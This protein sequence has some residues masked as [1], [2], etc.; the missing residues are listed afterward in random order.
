MK[1]PSIPLQIVY[2]VVAVKEDGSMWSANHSQAKNWTEDER[3]IRY[4]LRH[5]VLPNSESRALFVFCRL[6][7]ARG[8]VSYYKRLDLKSPYRIL[9]G[10]AANTRRVDN[11]NFEKEM[12]KVSQ[13]HYLSNLPNELNTALCDWFIPI[14]II[15]IK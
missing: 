8:G 13:E 6:D 9:R 15:K 14:G 11:S 2:K 5:Q 10:Y 1:I 12:R 3:I 4:R 7:D